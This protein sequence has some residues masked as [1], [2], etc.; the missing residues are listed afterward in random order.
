ME[1]YFTHD[2]VLQVIQI[3]QLYIQYYAILYCNTL[4]TILN[5]YFVHYHYRYLFTGLQSLHLFYLNFFPSITIKLHSVCM[6]LLQKSQRN[7]SLT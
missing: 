1:K 3:R 6:Y 2:K 5:I 7:L 4:D